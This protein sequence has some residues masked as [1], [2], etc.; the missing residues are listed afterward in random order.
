VLY[1][2]APK[3][4]TFLWATQYKLSPFSW[5]ST[6]DWESKQA[7][8]RRS[9]SCATQPLTFD[10]D[11]FRSCVQEGWP[12]SDVLPVRVYTYIVKPVRACPR[13]LFHTIGNAAFLLKPSGHNAGVANGKDNDG[14]LCRP[15]NTRPGGLAAETGSWCIRLLYRP[16]H[17]SPNTR[18]RRN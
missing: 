16:V 11:D 8:D 15:Y 2:S 13:L 10:A 1:S 3:F 6:L 4:G 12:I 5:R 14:A 7:E 17:T 18:R 9:T